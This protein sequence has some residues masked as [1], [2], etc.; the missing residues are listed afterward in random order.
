[1]TSS[2]HLIP[3]FHK[4]TLMTALLN[5]DINFFIQVILHKIYLLIN[6]Q[7]WARV[8]MPTEC[9]WFRWPS[10]I[11]TLRI[12]TLIAVSILESISSWLWRSACMTMSI[13]DQGKQ[14]SEAKEPYTS[15][16]LF[17][18]PLGKQGRS[19]AL[20]SS[21]SRSTRWRGSN[22]CGCILP[23]RTGTKESQSA[24]RRLF[25]RELRCWN[26]GFIFG[27]YFRNNKEF[28]GWSEFSGII[29]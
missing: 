21:L 17:R 7:L 14:S 10:L 15:T 26:L 3:N 22:G 29:F 8:L 6:R 13:S 2:T 23:L 16:C 5:R 20:P 1:L 11:P 18:K 4:I 24:V 19:C 28:K 25:T 27:F 9:V 12:L